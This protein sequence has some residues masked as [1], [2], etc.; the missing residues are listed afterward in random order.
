[1]NVGIDAL[2]F[3]TS[4]YYLDLQDLAQAR[5]IDVGKFHIG[6][7]QRK[8]A[9][10]PPGED[11]V[12]LAANAAE[13]VLQG[14]DLNSIELVLFATESGIDYSKSAGIYV[15]QLLNLPTRCRVVELKQAC[16][17][18]TVALQMAMAILRSNPTKKILLLASDIALYGLNTTGESSQGSGAVAMLLS[19]NPRLLEIQP[20]AGFY[21]K[22]AMDFWRPNY[23]HVPFV[24]GRYSCDL[25]MRLA[26]ETWKQYA[27][28]AQC[29]FQDHSHFCYHTPVPRLVERTHRRLA[30]HGL[31]YELSAEE[32]QTQ[33]GYS[34]VYSRDIGNCY[35][36]SLYLGVISLLENSPEDLS[37]RLIG[38]YSYGSGCSGEF[39]AAKVMPTY[40][41]MLPPISLRDFLDKRQR[42]T[43]TEYEQLYPLAVL[44]TSGKFTFPEYAT[45]N[46]RLTAVEQHK[47]IYQRVVC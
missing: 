7:G 14:V 20:M 47:R 30:K 41:Q 6:L 22:D 21:T 16:Y 36:A 37:N 17:S 23:C 13:Q 5:N 31:G 38:L 11:I 25:Y 26:E 2:S 43:Y 1:M 35:T 40:K 8:M 12:T 10:S 32:L 39:F 27:E 45:G 18:A 44:D 28:L 29:K 46:Y 9:M 34:L 24:D 4:H 42:L 19:V 3:C 15:H 33:V